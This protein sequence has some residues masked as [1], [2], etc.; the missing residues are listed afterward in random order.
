ML[1]ALDLET[2]GWELR[3]ALTGGVPLLQSLK[4]A[5]SLHLA[6][7]GA[8]LPSDDLD[9]A[10]DEWAPYDGVSAFER[11]FGYEPVLTCGN[12]GGLYELWGLSR[13]V[14]DG[15]G[16]LIEFGDLE[17]REDLAPWA[18]WNPPGDR[19]RYEEAFV[20]AYVKGWASIG[21]PPMLGDCWDGDSA[22]MRRALGALLEENSAARSDFSDRFAD[23]L[24]DSGPY[25]DWGVGEDDL[26]WASTLRG[27]GLIAAVEAEGSR[28]VLI[29][30]FLASSKG[31]P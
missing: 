8:E 23:A 21:L 27:E 4:H 17:S 12:P 28:D 14:V 9:E 15:H 22:L 16:F 2:M 24:D 13:S 30:I 7:S 6:N 1:L 29:R 19:E 3:E 11:T 31:C 18:D 20:R 5:G 10:L 25:P 26:A